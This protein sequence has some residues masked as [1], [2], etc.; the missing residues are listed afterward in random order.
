MRLKML[1]T[2]EQQQLGRLLEFALDRQQAFNLVQLEGFLFGIAMTPDT[3][4][5]SEWFEAI[6]GEAGAEFPDQEIA[7]SLLVDLARVL[8][9]FHRLYGEGALNFPVLLTEPDK[10][11][12][13]KLSDWAVGFDRALATRAELWMPDE[14][15]EKGIFTDEEDALMSSLM[16]VL[17]VAYPDR[18]CEVFE[19]ES[20]EQGQ[21]AWVTLAGQL[22]LA[23]AHL[24]GH[25]R[26]LDSQA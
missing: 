4:V 12:L 23:V 7:D 6:F 5:P 20:E 19:L 9:R 11:T 8:E 16:I 2:D 24:Q 18:I 25:A 26:Q 17:G 3:F 21:E 22:P 1:S 15:L 14:V 10:Q 13:A